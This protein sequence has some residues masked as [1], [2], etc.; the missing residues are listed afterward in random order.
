MR[1][2]VRTEGLDTG[3]VS[4][5][6]TSDSLRIDIFKRSSSLAVVLPDSVKLQILSHSY[7]LF[8][9]TVIQGHPFKMVL[10]EADIQ[11]PWLCWE[12]FRKSLNFVVTLSK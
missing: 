6:H 11:G 3:Q 4:R 12:K 5:T 7:P 10:K 2:A 9:W 1:G 8:V